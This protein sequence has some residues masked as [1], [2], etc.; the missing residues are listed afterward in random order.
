LRESPPIAAPTSVCLTNTFSTLDATEQ[1]TKTLSLQPL[2][3]TDVTLST[4]THTLKLYGKTVS[5][6][7]VASLV[8]MAYS[9]KTGVT[10]KVTV[11]AEEEGVAAAVVASV[12]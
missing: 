12:A 10:T 8:K 9:A 5:G 7:K 6:G 1:L 2:D 3:G 11:R 4:S